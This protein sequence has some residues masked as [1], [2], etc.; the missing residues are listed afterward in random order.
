MEQRH[1]RI[2][3][4]H[5]AT[6]RTRQ[7]AVSAMLP[8]FTELYGNPSSVYEF[9]AEP[10]RAI[11]AARKILADSIGAAPSEIYFTSGGSES[12]NWALTA[13]AEL[14]EKEGKKHI[15]TT[16]IEHHAILNTCSYLEERGFD[17]TCLRPDEQGCVSPE[18][19][20]AAIRPDTCLISVMAANNEI[21]TIEP[22]REIG[23]IARKHGILFHTDAVQAY[24]HMRIDVKECGIDMMSA[25]A[26]KLNGPRGVGFLYIRRG[27][28]VRSYIRG[29]AQEHGRRAGTENT[30]G[31]VGF[32]KA[33]ELAF[34]EL[35]EH[36]ET[37]RK[38][39]DHLLGRILTEIP[40]TVLNGAESR[41]SNNINVTFRGADAE[42]ILI[43][44]D[45]QGICASGGSACAS[46]SL[47]PSHVLTAIGRSEED[48]RA[49]VRLTVGYEN[50]EEEMD[51]AADRLK[52]IVARIR[53]M[54]GAE[55][56]S[57]R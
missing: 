31:I 4:D 36:A 45:M 40:D 19:V 49:A 42:S 24:G 43:M 28:R 33:A 47:D 14:G 46:G 27:V 55:H 5:A 23:M 25:S 39:R 35:D 11:A 18:S 29:G 7:E 48:A 1:N 54:R 8:Y 21:G 38:L 12:D 15:I 57:G 13:A 26:H 37:E 22:V 6:T 44:L 17:V 56:S 10:K 32:G 51:Y 2:Y 20:E 41:L 30:P 53:R 52:E 50:T 3:L 16:A 34:A 9:A